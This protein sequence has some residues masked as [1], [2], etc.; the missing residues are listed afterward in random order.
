MLSAGAAPAKGGARGVARVG[1]A[2]AAMP[3]AVHAGV[4]TGFRGAFGHGFGDFRR[5]EEFRR[6]DRDDRFRRFDRDDR[7]RR[8][9]NRR[10][11]PGFGRFGF[12]GNRDFSPG[13]FGGGYGG[14]YG[15][16]GGYGDTTGYGAAVADDEGPVP[17]TVRVPAEAEVWFDG[18]KDAQKGPVRRFRSQSPVAGGAASHLIRARWKAAGKTVERTQ[19]VEVG[20][21][22][23]VS[24]MFLGGGK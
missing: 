10:F 24:V 4:H 7:F 13:G 21:G 14:I 11:F 12:A 17:I 6:F 2:R 22:D 9:A 23:Q 5:R 18:N 19:R 8:F 20:S 3:R 1:G 16:L 15:Y